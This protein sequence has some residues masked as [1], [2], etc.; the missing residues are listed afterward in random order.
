MEGKG[1]K[2]KRQRRQEP[3]KKKKWRKKIDKYK[4]M[5][6]NE[7]MAMKTL[8]KSGQ[9][10]QTSVGTQRTELVTSNSTCQRQISN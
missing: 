10:P 1:E 9:D 7:S 2:E 5:N 8:H 6:R 4:K 3:E